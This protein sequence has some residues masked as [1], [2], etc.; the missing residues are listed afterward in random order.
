MAL[1]DDN[2][3]LKKE[4]GNGISLTQI[5]KCLRDYRVNTKGQRDLGLL[6]TSPKIKSDALYRP[7]EVGDYV[8]GEDV[9]NAGG[10]NGLYGYIIPMTSENSVYP[11]WGET[12]SDKGRPTA[13]YNICMFNNYSKLAE[14][15]KYPFGL[16]WAQAGSRWSVEYYCNIDMLYS[17]CPSHMEKFKTFY[18]AFQIFEEEEGVSVPS[19]TAIFS[20]CGRNPISNGVVGELIDAPTLEEGK[21]YYLIP[22]LSQYYFTT[23]DGEMGTLNGE[24]YCLIYKGFNEEDWMLGV[25][26]T[27]D[28]YS[29]QFGSELTLNGSYGAS[30]NIVL[31]SSIN[32]YD[33]YIYAGFRVWDKVSG[34]ETI[35]YNAW[36]PTINVGSG[37]VSP[38]SDLTLTVNVDWGGQTLT[39]NAKRLEVR[40][41]DPSKSKYWTNKYYLGSE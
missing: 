36:D 29:L 40:I 7:Y 17:V 3:R 30:F 38:D 6:A 18:P 12:W 19:T 33:A 41:Y 10:P 4:D 23:T 31:S 9:F 11:L 21:T 39:E 15:E 28:M 16:R 14:F 32:T 26:P 13:H 27:E 35:W 8:I 34:V 20:W 37:T 1:L 25:I 2:T 5:A 22:F 24:K